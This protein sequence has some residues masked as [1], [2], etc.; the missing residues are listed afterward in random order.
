MP[1]KEGPNTGPKPIITPKIL[2]ELFFCSSDTNVVIKA[3]EVACKAAAPIPWI[4]RP[5]ISQPILLAN[6]QKSELS[7]KR[8]NPK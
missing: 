5:A 3:A 1:P 6:P 8:T 4:T 2:I 7:P